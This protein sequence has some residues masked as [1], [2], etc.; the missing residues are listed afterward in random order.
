ML[1]H[2]WPQTFVDAGIVGV[3]VFFALSGYLITGLLVRDI[4]RFGRIRYG[5]FY[6]HRAIRLLPALLALLV[7]FALVEGLTNLNGDRD[8]VLRSVI[9]GITYTRNIPLIDHGSELLQHLWTLATEEQFY[10]VWPVILV[11]GARFRRMRLAVALAGAAIL[12]LLVLSLVWAAPDY[13]TVYPW[14]TSWAIAMVIGAAAQLGKAR[15]RGLLPAGS[16]RT[17]AVAGAAL[18]LLVV[19]SILPERNAGW[20]SYLIVGPVVAVATV[21]LIFFLTQWRSLPT[22]SLRPL[23]WLGTVSYAAYLWNNPLVGWLDAAGAAGWT[24]ILSII[25]TLV[26]AWLS[27]ILVE[28]PANRLRVRLDATSRERASRRRAPVDA[29]HKAT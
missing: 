16:P 27:W 18:L 26:F 19:L 5:R 22:P 11:L 9:V 24:P 1:R 14:P 23:L 7:A 25:L 15:I 6:L 12:G 28:R 29:K 8:S 20:S 21:P 4:S 10:L 17:A 2:A 3:V 13:G